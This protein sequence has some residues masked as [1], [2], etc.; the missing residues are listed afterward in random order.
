MLFP[1]CSRVQSF[2]RYWHK[3]TVFLHKR[4]SFFK[5]ILVNLTFR[6]VVPFKRKKKNFGTYRIKD[7]FFFFTLLLETRNVTLERSSVMLSFIFW[8]RVT[9]S[10][11]F[12]SCTHEIVHHRYFYRVWFPCFVFRFDLV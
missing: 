12:I 10:Q 11:V 9:T 7:K 8:T 3:Y 2:I 5:R 1:N 4:K 6:A